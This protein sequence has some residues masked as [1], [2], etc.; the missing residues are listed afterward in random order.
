MI[1]DEYF[2][3]VFKMSSFQLVG[4]DDPI[5]TNIIEKCVTE[6]AEGSDCDFTLKYAR[7]GTYQLA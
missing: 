6:T 2:F 7:L 4:G 1:E 5:S 3:N